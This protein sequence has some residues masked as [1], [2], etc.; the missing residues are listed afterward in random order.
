[1]CNIL[2]GTSVYGKQECSSYDQ[3]MDVR[4]YASR[5]AG[6][7]KGNVIDARRSS[8]HCIRT[9]DKLFLIGSLV[10]LDTPSS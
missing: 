4:W 2:T 3:S 9:V 10:F 8:G 6:S 1:M 5:L 7:A